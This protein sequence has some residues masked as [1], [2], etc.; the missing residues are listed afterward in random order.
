MIWGLHFSAANCMLLGPIGCLY[1]RA[2]VR[3]LLDSHWTVC[4]LTMCWDLSFT[5]CWLQSDPEAF[6]WYCQ[7]VLHCDIFQ[8]RCQVVL[9]LHPMIH[10]TQLGLQDL[11]ESWF[12]WVC[13]NSTGPPGPGW[14]AATVTASNTCCWVACEGKTSCFSAKGKA[15]CFLARKGLG[16]AP[17]AK[18]CW[19]CSSCGCE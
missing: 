10:Q 16:A 5:K 8:W 17:N 12:G 18:R 14:D 13:S 3:D 9:G 15:T 1:H 11:A 4:F 6:I 19:T 7:C 2:A